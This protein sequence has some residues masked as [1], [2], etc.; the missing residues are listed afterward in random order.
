LVK[1]GENVMFLSLIVFDEDEVAPP[2]T[3][4]F[5]NVTSVYTGQ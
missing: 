5:G 1:V 2:G 4:T 3:L